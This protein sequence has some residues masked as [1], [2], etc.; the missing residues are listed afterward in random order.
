[1]IA[2][3]LIIAEEVVLAALESSQNLGPLVPTALIVITG[4]V[5][6]WRTAIKILAIAVVLLV[7]LGLAELMHALH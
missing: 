1:M 6:F 7:V 2:H 5:V 4:L 3:A